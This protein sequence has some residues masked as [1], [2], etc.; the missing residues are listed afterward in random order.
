MKIDELFQ[1]SNRSVDISSVIDSAIRNSI[2]YYFD[3]VLS[4]HISSNNVP[5]MSTFKPVN[6][7]LHNVFERELYTAIRRKFF[8]N[9]NDKI[10]L[11]GV[12]FGT[13]QNSKVEFVSNINKDEPPELTVHV[14]TAASAQLTQ[15]FK[16]AIAN[17]DNNFNSITLSQDVMSSNLYQDFKN[18]MVHKLEDVYQV[19]EVARK[20]QSS[21]EVAKW[22]EHK[23]K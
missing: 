21:D 2:R 3:S 18:I 12:I 6:W 5:N 17:S 7:Q 20:L 19:T 16:H 1:E 10:H 11:S 15:S 22:I 8:N 13:D 4:K 23:N 14:G 9:I